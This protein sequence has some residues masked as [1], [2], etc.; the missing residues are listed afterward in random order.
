M[1]SERILQRILKMIQNTDLKSFD[2]P[3]VNHYKVYG[4]T[5]L[6]AYPLPLFWNGSAIEVNV[7]GT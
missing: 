2:L 7:T 3:H 4:R 5:D 1:I 6:E